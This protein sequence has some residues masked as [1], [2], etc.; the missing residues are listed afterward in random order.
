MTLDFV[1]PT[2]HSANLN[3]FLYGPPG[4]SKTT[5]ALSAPGPILYLNAEGGNAAMFARR[6]HA[7]TEIREVVV[8]SGE[9][10][11]EALLYARAGNGIET[12][13]LDSLGA[14]FQAVLEDKTG[15]GKPT[16]PQY[17]DTTTAIERFARALRD[18]PVNVVLIAHEQAVKDEVSGQFERL[19]FTGTT[20]PAL[21]IKLMAQAD[22]VGYTG[23]I[24]G[25]EENPKTRYVAQLFDAGGR[26]GKDR[27]DLLGRFPELN[28][29]AWLEQYR[30]ALKPTTNG[31][32]PKEA[33]PA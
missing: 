33:V 5:G 7:G 18:L 32:T 8:D 10:L 27:T 22:V 13:V 4:S 24:E 1:D 15:G 29:I 17:G 23:L 30:Q 12:V 25:D 26:R 20:N 3:I 21:G 2:N 11:N 31:A 16:L 9:V 28:I 19:P 6:L 14:I